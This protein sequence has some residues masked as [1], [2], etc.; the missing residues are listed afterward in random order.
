MTISVLLP[1]CGNV[2]CPSSKEC[3]S[4]SC[5]AGLHNYNKNRFLFWV[6]LCD[7]WS[8]LS[9]SDFIVFRW[10]IDLLDVLFFVCLTVGFKNL[11]IHALLQQQMKIT[12]PLLVF[13]HEPSSRISQNIWKLLKALLPVCICFVGEWPAEALWGNQSVDIL[14]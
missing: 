12:K 8:A 9:I 6:L 2:S 5:K 10:W 1:I 3:C 11:C 4:V 14:W 7:L 13:Y